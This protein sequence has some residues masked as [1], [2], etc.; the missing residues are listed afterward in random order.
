MLVDDHR[1]ARVFELWIFSDAI[2]SHDDR[3]VFDGSRGEQGGPVVGTRVG[4][5]RD[6]GKEI[7][8]CFHASSKEFGKSQVVADNWAHSEALPIEDEDVFSG[9]VAVRFACVAEAVVLLVASDALSVGSEYDEFVAALAVALFEDQSAQSPALVLLGQVGEK[10]FG[11]RRIR[12]GDAIDVHAEAAREHFRER[13]ERAGLDCFRFEQRANFIEVELP[14][15]PLDIELAS[16]YLHSVVGLGG[17]LINAIKARD[18][19]RALPFSRA[20]LEH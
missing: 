1:E 7:S 20:K 2:D 9:V 15:L 3:L 5:V 4:P 13:D 16:D 19:A 14:V 18:G 6:D 12:F 17:C 10:L 8:A 11:F